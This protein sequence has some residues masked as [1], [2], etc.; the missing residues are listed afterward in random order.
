MIGI[1]GDINMV[2]N[3]TIHHQILECLSKITEDFIKVRDNLG[4]SS[5]NQSTP[6]SP[7]FTPPIH[8]ISPWLFKAVTLSSDYK[9]GKLIAYKLLCLTTVRNHDIPLSME[10]LSL[11]YRTIHQGLMSYDMVLL[12]NKK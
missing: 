6:P 8:F 10:F 3:P 12:Y 7:S 5:D 2:N 4:I 11:F 1:L 9:K